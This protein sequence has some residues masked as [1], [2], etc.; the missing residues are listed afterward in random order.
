[1]NSEGKQMDL[2]FWPV[3]PD[4]FGLMWGDDRISFTLDAMVLDGDVVCKKL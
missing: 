2:K 3:G 1:M 4:T